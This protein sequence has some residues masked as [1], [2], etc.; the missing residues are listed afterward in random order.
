MLSKEDL[1]N[2]LINDVQAFNQE[3]NGKPIDLSEMDFS[4][5]SIDGANFDNVDLTSSSFADAHL[6]DVKFLGCDLTSVDFNRANLVECTFNE[7]I[8]NGTDFSYSKVDYCNFTDADLAGAIMLDGDFTNSDFS[9]CENLNASRF[10]D[11]TIWPENEYLPEDFD[12]SYS[13]DLSSL[14][15]DDDYE[16]SDY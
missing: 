12:S 8:L 5:A 10:D 7:S 11:S 4:S 1:A 16:V 6:V 9:M 15:D 2:L 3:I 13:D 14:K